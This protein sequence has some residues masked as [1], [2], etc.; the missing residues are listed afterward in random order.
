MG[1]LRRTRVGKILRVLKKKKG[2]N[3]FVDDGTEVPEVSSS[4]FIFN[5]CT[6]RFLRRFFYGIKGPLLKF[7]NQF[8]SENRTIA[9][10]RVCVYDEIMSNFYLVSINYT[11]LMGQM[12]LLQNQNQT[13]NFITMIAII[14]VDSFNRL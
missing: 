7:K 14:S 8:S 4:L 3:H 1:F 9:G 5:F 2:K 13:K 11:E 10:L 6:A 12:P